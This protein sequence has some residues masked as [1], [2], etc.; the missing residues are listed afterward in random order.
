MVAQV[1]ARRDLMRGNSRT[2]AAI[3]LQRWYR[4]EFHGRAPI[5]RMHKA[6]VRLQ[7]AFRQYR[8]TLRVQKLRLERGLQLKNYIQQIVMLKPDRVGRLTHFQIVPEGVPVTTR[9]RRFFVDISAMTKRQQSDV[10]AIIRPLQAFWHWKYYLA[11]VHKI[12]GLARGHLSRQALK[13]RHASAAKIQA[14]WRCNV[15]FRNNGHLQRMVRKIQANARRWTSLRKLAR[16]GA[17][18]KNHKLTMFLSARSIPVPN[19][20][21]DEEGQI[22]EP[23]MVLPDGC[24][25]AD[26]P[27]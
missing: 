10:S 17:V 9:L 6:A 26:I 1:L 27:D 3:T 7:S 15:E 14:A 23:G 21:V 4:G 2:K 13:R 12:Q 18:E 8:A 5:A 24:V 20:K 16:E 11:C 19:L 25:V 22:V